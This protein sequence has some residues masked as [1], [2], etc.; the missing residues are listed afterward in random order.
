MTRAVI[1]K[2]NYMNM[3]SYGMEE[4]GRRQGLLPEEKDMNGTNVFG[5]DG[6]E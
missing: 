6:R 4:V 1:D 3:S 5:A 2:F